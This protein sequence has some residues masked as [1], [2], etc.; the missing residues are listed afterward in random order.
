MF[1]IT[2]EKLELRV[3]FAEGSG[4]LL[5]LWETPCAHKG[6]FVM[7]Q[8]HQ[9]QQDPMAQNRTQIGIDRVPLALILAISLR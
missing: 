2:V 7:A 5:K 4:A 8:T 1:I 9:S 6:P 3:C